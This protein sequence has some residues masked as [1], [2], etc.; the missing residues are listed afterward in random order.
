[1]SALK[2]LLLM[3]GGQPQGEGA[4]G[5]TGDCRSLKVG[6]TVIRVGAR[7]MILHNSSWRARCCCHEVYGLKVQAGAWPALSRRCA[8]GA[9]QALQRELL[10]VG[11]NDAQFA[12]QVLDLLFD[13]NEQRGSPIPLSEFHNA[14]VSECADLKQEYMVSIL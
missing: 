12:V 4:Q 9:A 13:A 8:A 5:S 7:G 1:M 3:A 14:S 11:D 10:T 6:F 2:G